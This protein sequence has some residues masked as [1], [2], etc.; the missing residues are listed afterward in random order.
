MKKIITL[1][2]LSVLFFQQVDARTI[3]W[4]RNESLYRAGFRIGCNIPL[5]HQFS[6]NRTS[7]RMFSPDFAGYFRVGKLVFGEIGIGYTFQKN[8]FAIDQGTGVYDK[9]DEIVEMRFLQIPLR[10]VGEFELGE[11]FSL[12]PSVG[13][14]YQ[15]LLHVNDNVLGY[16]KKNLTNHYFVLTAGVGFSVYFFSF[17]LSYRHFLQN[18]V[19]KSD[20]KRQSTLHLSL[21][22]QI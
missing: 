1:L 9:Y 8:R 3:K 15:P 4:K 5:T 2:F 11:F 20:V 14:I 6:E 17:E 18:W 16:S 21:G 12:Q 19:P 22:F 13:F 7:T 10:A